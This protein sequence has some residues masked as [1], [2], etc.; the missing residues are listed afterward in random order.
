LLGPRQ[1]GKTTLLAALPAAI[2]VSL[3]EPRVRQRYERDP[4]L[5]GAEVRALSDRRP[6]VVLDEVQRVPAL[7]DVAQGLIDDR[8]AQ[9]VLTGSSARKLK[10]GRDVNLLPGRVVSLRLDPLT[11]EEDSRASLSDLLTLGALPGIR[12]EPSRADRSEDLRS[13]VES[14]LEEEVR[15]EALVKQLAPFSRFLELAALESGRIANFRAIASDIGVSAP[16]VAAYYEILVD[17]LVAER[18][19]PITESTTRK[20]LTKSARF[21]FFDLGV[22]R[23]AANEGPRLGQHRLGELFEQLVGLEL[24]RLGRLHRPGSRL[25][26][27]RAP[28]GPEVDWVVEHHGVYVPVEVKWT[29]RPRPE[30]AKHVATFLAEHRQA[31]QG[32]VVCRVPRPLRL[33]KTI[34]AVPWQSLAEAGGA[35][36]DA[37]G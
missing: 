13:Y 22:R 21:L 33:T 6:L 35:V 36:F 10:R 18:I 9:L 23:E 3:V 29:D 14:Y 25:R 19:E 20:R 34:T 8:R 12:T 37:L 32:F 31:R 24:I 28:E 26:F 1:T 5:F 15:Q 7:M 27:W 4:S 30:D 11:L 16:T 17:C 2:R